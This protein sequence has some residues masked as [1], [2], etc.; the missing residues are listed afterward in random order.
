MDSNNLLRNLLFLCWYCS[1]LL[2][3]VTHQSATPVSCQIHSLDYHLNLEDVNL[4]VLLKQENAKVCYLLIFCIAISMEKMMHFK[5]ISSG[6]ILFSGHFG[7]IELPVPIY[8]PSHVSELKRILSLVCLSCLKM[9]KTKVPPT[10]LWT[11]ISSYFCYVYITINNNL[12]NLKDERHLVVCF[13]F[14]LYLCIYFFNLRLKKG[15]LP[16]ISSFFPTFFLLSSFWTIKASYIKTIFNLS[17]TIVTPFFY[18]FKI[19]LSF[20]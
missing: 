12:L 16:L 10:G 13:D 6:S 2:Q 1:A 19:F 7:Y 9:K 4:V 3:S 11:W 17:A 14:H 5:W 15:C 20:L 8:H 18:L